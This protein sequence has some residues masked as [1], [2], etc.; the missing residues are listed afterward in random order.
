MLAVLI[1]DR[2]DSLAIDL[3]ELSKRLAEEV[4]PTVDGIIGVLEAR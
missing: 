3:V 4:L 1:V 2:L